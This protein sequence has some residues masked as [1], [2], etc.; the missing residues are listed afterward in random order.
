M[1]WNVI[2]RYWIE[3]EPMY[4][5]ATVECHRHSNQSLPKVAVT[6]AVNEDELILR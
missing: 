4:F 5:R 2:I 1:L 6:I 3:H